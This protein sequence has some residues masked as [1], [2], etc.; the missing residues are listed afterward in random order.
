MKKYISYMVTC[1]GDA[2]WRF[3]NRPEWCSMSGM[4]LFDADKWDI[5]SIANAFQPIFRDYFKHHGWTL[6][7]ELKFGYMYVVPFINEN[8]GVYVYKGHTGL[9][10]P[11]VPEEKHLCP[12]DEQVTRWSKNGSEYNGDYDKLR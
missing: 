4:L 8:D 6:A 5:D 2:G 3:S 9:S 11:G 1:G 10:F 12:P 7:E